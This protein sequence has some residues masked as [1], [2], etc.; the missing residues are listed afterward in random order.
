MVSNALQAIG[1]HWSGGCNIKKTLFQFL[2][3]KTAPQEGFSISKKLPVKWTFDRKKLHI[4][5]YWRL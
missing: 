3:N 4:L 2:T 1:Y 5:N